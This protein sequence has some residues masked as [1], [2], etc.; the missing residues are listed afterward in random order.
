MATFTLTID[1][2]NA[3]FDDNTGTEIARILRSVAR[4]IEATIHERTDEDSSPL[5]DVNGNRVGRWSYDGES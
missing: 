2:G 4:V 5:H 1:C 3:A